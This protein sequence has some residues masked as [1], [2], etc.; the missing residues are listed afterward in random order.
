MSLGSAAIREV[1]DSRVSDHTL[2]ENVI[3][4]MFDLEN[5]SSGSSH[6]ILK[7]VREID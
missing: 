5:S 6:V 7:S 1:I 2:D 3:I 4:L